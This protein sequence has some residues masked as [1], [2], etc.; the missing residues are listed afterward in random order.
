[1]CGSIRAAEAAGIVILYNARPFH[2]H[3]VICML[4]STDA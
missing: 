1:M 2:I 3:I 4:S